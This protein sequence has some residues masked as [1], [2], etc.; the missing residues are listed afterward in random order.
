MAAASTTFGAIS[1]PF[2]ATT[3]AIFAGEIVEIVENVENSLWKL[4][5]TLR[6]L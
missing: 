5:K 4:W 2:G 6:F 1:T 3:G